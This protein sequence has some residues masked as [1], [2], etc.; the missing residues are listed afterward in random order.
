MTRYT[1][2]D[3]DFPE[4]TEIN[5]VVD[6]WRTLKGTRIGPV[7]SEIDLLQLPADIIPRVCVVDVQSDPQD[8]IYRFWGTAITDMHHYDLT[9]KS[10]SS[11]TP[12]EYAQCL[13]EQYAQVVA[14]GQG[15]GFLTEV[16][17]PSGLFT[18]YSCVRLPLSSDGNTVDAVL[19]AEEYG[20]Q[21]GE[22]RDLFET[23]WLEQA[24]PKSP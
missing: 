8:F 17:Q 7:W 11:L 5:A 12:P 23:V 13:V 20:E 3:I 1:S 24:E 2:V 10:V 9:G 16:P 21:V 6:Y 19:S 22:L 15:C 14:G 4:F 18:H